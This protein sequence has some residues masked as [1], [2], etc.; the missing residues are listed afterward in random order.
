MTKSR[1]F[2]VTLLAI[3]ALLAALV[4]GY[5]TLQMLHLLPVRLFGGEF[6]FFTFDLFGAFMWGIMAFIYL[7]VFRML[8]NLDQQGWLFVTVIAVLNLLLAFV[9]IFGET[10]WQELLPS[11]VI[12]GLILI[13]AL[14]P[15]TKAAF[16]V[17]SK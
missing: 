9:S 11:I 14:L 15:G 13:Y 10:T 16:G 17:P 1:P 8:W 5:H 4:A 2:G 6:K 12:N 3:F 7:W